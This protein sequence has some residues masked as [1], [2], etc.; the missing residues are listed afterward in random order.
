MLVRRLGAPENETK[1][2]VSQVR[3]DHVRYVF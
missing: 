2:V 3:D 1:R